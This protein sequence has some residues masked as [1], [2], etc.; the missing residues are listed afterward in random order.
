MRNKITKISTTLILCLAFT[1]AGAQN[2]NKS[3][4]IGGD[5]VSELGKY[6]DFHES[7]G[8]TEDFSLRFSIF[9]NRLISS[10]TFSIPGLGIN[11]N[12]FNN[13]ELHIYGSSP[14]ATNLILSANYENSYRW[15]FKTTDRGSAIDLDIVGTNQ[16]DQEE[17]LIKLSPSFS[18]RP[19]LSFMNDWLVVNNGNI[20][21]GTLT[22]NERLSVNGNIRAREIKVEATNWPDYVFGD[23][24]AIMPL[25]SLEAY[26]KSEKHLPEMPSAA[27]VESQGISLGEM[28]KMLLKKVEE[29]TLHLIEKDHQINNQQ[30][31]MDTMNNDLQ[32]IKLLLKDKLNEKK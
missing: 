16:A 7:D 19:E 2:W 25:D 12:S 29:L 11:T 21:M 20:G 6:I 26:I 10:G 5:G 3:I 22:P 27:I 18:G 31:K 14:S 15:K 28:N 8:G 13:N 9:G 17:Q 4:Y 23:K 1:A 24:Y 30:K 32:E